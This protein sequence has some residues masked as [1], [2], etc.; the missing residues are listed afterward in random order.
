MLRK[1]DVRPAAY[2]PVPV[3]QN[4]IKLTTEPPKGLRANVIRSFLPMSDEQ[5][6]TRHLVVAEMFGITRKFPVLWKLDDQRCWGTL[7]VC[8]LF[9]YRQTHLLRGEAD[10]TRYPRFSDKST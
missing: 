9:L 10:L 7:Y 8:I 6:G 2:F 4:G 5:A 3:L 1:A